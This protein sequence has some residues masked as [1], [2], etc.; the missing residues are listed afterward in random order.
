[1]TGLTMQVACERCGEA[2]RDADV[3]F[4]CS[5]ECTF[6]QPCAQVMHFS[7]PNCGGELLRRPRREIALAAGSC[8][9]QDSDERRETAK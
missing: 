8:P 5:Y 9:T 4:I 7:C 1:M 3:A 6:C 2:L